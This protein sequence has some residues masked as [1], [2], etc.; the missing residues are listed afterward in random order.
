M[1]K[2][3]NIKLALF[4]GLRYARAR[5]GN[6][7]LSLLSLSSGL[8]MT[9]G[10]AVLIIVMS[11]MNGFESELHTRIL[12]MV[13][14]I[15]VSKTADSGAV[16]DNWEKLA[17]KLKTH[18]EVKAVAPVIQLQG[19]LS[20]AGAVAGVKL[21]GVL[22]ELEGSV[23]VFPQHMVEGDV[24]DLQLNSDGLILG[25]SLARRLSLNIGDRVTFIYPEPS[26][27]GVGVVPRFKRFQLVGV[28]NVGSEYDQLLGVIHINTAADFLGK[29]G[30]IAGLRL[31]VHNLYSA[32]DV[33][34]QLSALLGESF[35]VLDWTVV[36]GNFFRAVSLE[37]SMMGFL[38]L[39]IVAIAAFNIVS[40][41]VML[42][43]DKTVDIAVLRTLGISENVIVGVFVIQGFYVGLLGSTAG[44]A[45][46]VLG[47]NYLS[48]WIT[49]LE[50]TFNFGLFDAYVLEQLPSKLEYFDVGLIAGS[51]LLMSLF[52]TIYPALRASR[53][54]P[55]EAFHYD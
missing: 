22:P 36:H 46:G 43:S 39:L 21:N 37:K 41:L 26:S 18:V 49:L 5:R 28:F 1:N 9:L 15:T 38:L 55:A 27:H 16:I 45:I 31:R 17:D 2:Y 20:H 47:A 52:A 10:I 53:I 14:H 3:A 19:M 48:D 12:G 44:V 40:S 23:S 34:Q 11:V 7:F 29:P 6:R 32:P 24:N 54:E 13:T 33:R 50:Q 35:K 51:A 8:G 30:W 42:V 4:I 25:I